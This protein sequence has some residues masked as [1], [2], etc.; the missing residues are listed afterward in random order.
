MLTENNMIDERYEIDPREEFERRFKAR[1]VERLM[2]PGSTWER[3]RAEAAA[4][5]EWSAQTEDS[6]WDCDGDPE[7]AADECLSY[8]DDD[9]E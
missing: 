9:G 7:S 3:A 5:A 2:M 6:E 1:I 8:W 4:N